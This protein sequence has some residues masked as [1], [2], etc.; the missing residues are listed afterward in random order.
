MP[1]V[2][3]IAGYRFFFFSNETSEPPHIHVE[4][5][6]CSAKFWLSPPALARNVGFRS[7]ELTELHRLL[8]EHQMFFQERWNG[9]FRNEP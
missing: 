6:E 4:R 2:L 7:A 9:Y 1:T 8:R 5:A 3:R